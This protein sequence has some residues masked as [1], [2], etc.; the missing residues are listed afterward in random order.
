MP[1]R[2]KAV[3]TLA[4]VWLAASPASG[5][6]VT[7]VATAATDLWPVEFDVSL[8][9]VGSIE[10]S[11]IAREQFQTN[12]QGVSSLALANALSYRRTTTTVPL[13]VAAGIWHNLELH[14]M[15][16]IVIDDDQHW[17]ASDGASGTISQSAGIC[18]EGANSPCG[19]GVLPGSPQNTLVPYTLPVD[20]VRGQFVVGDITIGIAWAPLVEEDTPSFPTWLLGFDYVAPNASVMNPTK[21]SYLNDKLPVGSVGDGLHHFRPYS[22]LS[23]RK[24]AFDPYLSLWFDFAHATGSTYD[25]CSSP[26]PNSDGDARP[27]CDGVAPFTTAVT[28]L[29]PET[30][31]GLWFGSELVPYESADRQKRFS[32]DL[33]L[34]AEFHS[35]SRSYSQL[36][37]LLQTLTAQQEYGRLGGQVGMV[38]H[39]SRFF[40]ASLDFSLL[41]DTDHWLTQETLGAPNTSNESVNLATHVGQNPNYDFRY[42]AP[43][44]RFRLQN[45]VIGSLAFNLMVSL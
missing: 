15:V 3:M 12:G 9:F 40:R 26:Y 6:E 19:N 34:I 45:S 7:H 41:H 17:Q 20:S 4:A 35:D 10:Q 42:D 18:P 13:R 43:G 30:Q 25:N 11:D 2:L 8:G 29:Q 44:S 31:V 21:V 38:I 27:N 28:R 33:R 16:P 37:D 24:G 14:V 23:K 22:A 36:S 32:F 39:A 1:E 5:A